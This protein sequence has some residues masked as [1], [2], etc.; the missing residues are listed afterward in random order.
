[1]IL[2]NY[3]SAIDREVRLA[4]GSEAYGRVEVNYEGLW[5]TIGDYNWENVDAKVICRQLGFPSDGRHGATHNANF[6]E[7]TGNIW[8]DNI[9]CD[10]NEGNIRSCGHN[11]W[12]FHNY[13]HN[14]DAGV[15]CDRGKATNTHVGI[16]FYVNVEYLNI[17]FI[18]LLYFV[19]LSRKP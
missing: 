15:Y 6:G 4:D 16:T 5:G 14:R 11:G 13:E 3:F 12:G 7:G 2:Y 10:G 1:M 19:D 17:L 8:L 18:Y 9:G